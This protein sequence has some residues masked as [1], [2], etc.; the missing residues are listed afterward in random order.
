MV[1]EV[2]KRRTP[3]KDELLDA[4]THAYSEAIN[5]YRRYD[6]KWSGLSRRDYMQFRRPTDPSYRSIERALG[7]W[8]AFI[9]LVPELGKRP[10]PGKNGWESISMKRFY[11]ILCDIAEESGKSVWSVTSHDYD[12]YRNNNPDKNIRSRQM[13][14]MGIGADSWGDALDYLRY[15]VESKEQFDSRDR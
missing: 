14:T 7:S 2:R 11:N 5:H 3:D 10:R 1:G 12:E 4:L 6:Q 15:I 13:Y 8:K 9:Q